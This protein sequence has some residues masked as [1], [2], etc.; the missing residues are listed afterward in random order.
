MLAIDDQQD[1]LISLKALLKDAFPAGRLQTA[2]SGSSGIALA[3]TEDPDVI[4]L[5]VVMPGMDGFEVC[6]RLKADA[7]TRDIPVV[8]LT[9][10]QT[11]RALRVTALEAGAEA[12]L[13]KPIDELELT[14]QVQA[15]AKIKAASI[16]KRD[17]TKRLAALVAE[18]T[19]ELE[20]SRT[21]ALKLLE[22]LR[23][24]NEAR[25]RVETELLEA[26]LL[27]QQIMASA[28]EGII[29]YGPDLRYRVWNPYMESLGGR[30]ASDVLGKHPMELFPFLKD[31][32][33]M[34][35]LQRALLGETPES[36]EFPFN[37]N[38]K[39]GW[40]LDR[41][42]PLRNDKGEIIGVLAVVLDITERKQAEDALQESED[43][44][45]HVFQ[46]ANVGKC[47]TL[48]TG[49]VLANRAFCE[50]LGYSEQELRR[51]TW[52]ELTPLDEIERE[53]AIAASLL[54]GEK[55]AARFCKRYSHKNGSPVWADVSVV[56]RRDSAGNPL[57]FI[58]T[59]ID[60]SARMQAEAERQKLEEQLRAS[61]KMEAIGSLAGGVAHDFNNLLSVILTYT[62]FV[63][64]AVP[65]GAPLQEDLLEVKKA[66][67]R[68]VG[69]TRQ[70]L[71]F[72][73]K[74]LLRT[75]P[76]NLN[77]SAVEI[78]KML[79]RILGEDIDYVQ[80]LAPDLGIVQADPGQMEQVLMNLVVN[81]RDAMPNGGKL[82]IETHNVEIDEEYAARHLAVTPGS[83]VQLVITDTGSGMDEQTKARLFEP[84]FTTKEKG[85]GTGLGLSTV[86]GIVSQSGGSIWVYSELGQGTTFKIYLP[87]AHSAKAMA[88]RPPGVA[89]RATGTETVLV[90]EDEEALR[91]V[92]RRSL[93]AAGYTVLTAA[94][95]VDALGTAARHAG[96]IQLLLTD[97]V[98]PRM[99]GRMA[100]QELVKT[101]PAL[102]VL[103]MS[104]YTADAIVHHGVLDAGT[105]FIGK[106]FTG[107]D[108][109]RKVREVL[110]GG[111][112][113]TADGQAM[114]VESDK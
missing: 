73:R 57:H 40:S 104:G 7:R 89:T 96:E 105:Q 97:V 103:Y 31:V 44:F 46:A 24:E 11:D 27:H 16:L 39:S 6:R 71:A 34:A 32:G 22:D 59:I 12:F 54:S 38:G 47:I 106:P 62:A 79:R 2:T 66:A 26:G 63:R 92:V 114:A 77:K 42:S 3:V 72:S 86:Y 20:Q 53:Q 87:R 52:Q 67:D 109:T 33:V 19:W 74:Q 25:Q 112:A 107:A 83:Y 37:I 108:L 82:T 94:D 45:K 15:M 65:E 10:L 4:L 113:S 100:A 93:E 9:A 5:D 51:K 85:K 69:L 1:N 21:A 28:N 56:L 111:A 64:E 110:D 14:A 75:V 99:G 95:G 102:R 50:L 81:A 84:F 48:P 58:T 70:L 17:E 30:A 90:V 35:L 68:A 80:V 78:E 23:A 43:K 29:V 41:S 98:M 60:I 13:S 61:Q 91:K 76:L 101:R 18:R 55:D 49:E 88:T 8:F 36:L